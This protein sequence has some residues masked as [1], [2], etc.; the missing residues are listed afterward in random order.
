MYLFLG[1]F[2]LI[3]NIIFVLQVIVVLSDRYTES[4]FC[5]SE[6]DMAV[7]RSKLT[8]KPL[9]TVLNLGCS[10]IKKMTK[11]KKK[12]VSIYSIE[13]DKSDTWQ[14]ELLKQLQSSIDEIQTV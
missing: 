11:L 5:R 7:C 4:A 6:L 13:N 8:N 14:D 12:T 2:W 1:S 9:L 3:T 10:S